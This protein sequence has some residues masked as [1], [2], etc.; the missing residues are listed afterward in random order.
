MTISE[1]FKKRNEIIA[2]V[3]EARLQHPEG[4]LHLTLE[5]AATFAYCSKMTIR[6]KIHGKKIKANRFGRLMVDYDSLE[7]YFQVTAEEAI[8]SCRDKKR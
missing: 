2:A 8:A 5:E 7:S 1:R 6:R 4:K 3:Q